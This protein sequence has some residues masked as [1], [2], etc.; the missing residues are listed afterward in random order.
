MH[1]QGFQAQSGFPVCS[2]TPLHAHQG[3]GHT[4]SGQTVSGG[5]QDPLQLEHVP[6]QHQPVLETN[7]KTHTSTKYR[8]KCIIN[9]K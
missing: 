5:V 3:E 1:L 9:F 6:L 8:Q 2:H 7:G 4:T